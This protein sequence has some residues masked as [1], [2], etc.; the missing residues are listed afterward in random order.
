[1]VSMT[2]IQFLLSIG[3]ILLSLL[4]GYIIVKLPFINKWYLPA[5]L[6]GGL[7]LL[8]FGPQIAGHHFPEW[9]LSSSFYNEWARLPGLL[10]NVVFASLFLGRNLVPLKEVWK[11]AAPQAAFGQTLAWGQYAI[12]GLV[13]LFIL[14]PPAYPIKKDRGQE[15]PTS[16]NQVLYSNNPPYLML[17]RTIRFYSG[18][19][20]RL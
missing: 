1:M 2:G 8:V 20:C 18:P 19:R 6:I 5:S 3:I 7:I 13:T 15:I 4:I 14:I 16:V 10:I 9:Q 12:G 11:M 17:W